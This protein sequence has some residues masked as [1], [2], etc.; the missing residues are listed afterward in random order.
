MSEQNEVFQQFLPSFSFLK[1]K[2]SR[3]VTVR[4]FSC[5]YR[6]EVVH[7]LANIKCSITVRCDAGGL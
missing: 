7:G 1:L 6:C 3:G 2:T 5:P 4:M